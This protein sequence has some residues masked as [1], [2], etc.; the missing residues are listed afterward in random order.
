MVFFQAALLAGYGYAHL[1]TSRLETRRQ[2]IVHAVLLTLPLWVLPISIAANRV[3]PVD[4]NPIPWLL[5]LMVTVVGLP[6]LVVSTTAPLLQQWFTRTGHR[7]AKDPYFLY[8]ASN[9]GSLL[10]LLA[11]PTLV[12]PHL[13]LGDQ[14]RWWAIGYGLFV[15]CTIGC[16]W[17]VLRVAVR[18]TWRKRSS[19][20]VSTRRDSLK[21]LP[22][23]R[24][25]R[26]VMLAFV[27]SSLMLGIT[28][29][30]STD[31]AAIPLLWVIPLALYLLTFILVFARR[32]IVSQA[33]MVRLMPFVILPLVTVMVSDKTQP[34]WLLI[35]LHVLTFFVTAM[36]C[37]GALAQDRP[38]PNRL[39]EFYL[40]LSVGGVLGGLFN[41]LIAPVVFDTVMEYPLV[42]ILACLLR[43]G[44][45]TTATRSQAKWL[46]YAMPAALA[47]TIVALALNA[48]TVGPVADP[49]TL[50][51]IAV[52]ATLLC[53]SFRQRPVRF[54]LA[55]GAFLLIGR[56]FTTG[57]EYA[58]HIE[59]SFFGVY[60]VLRTHNETGVY[61]SL[62][63]GT[64][65][66]G[67][68]SRDP[69]RQKEPLTYYHPS[70]PLGDIMSAFKQGH[71]PPRIA[72][73]G[74][75]TGSISCFSRPAQQWTFYEIDPVIQ[76]IATNPH[77][78]S[79]VNTCLPN[80]R[81][82][83]G[84]A[85]LSLARAPD[86]TYGLIVVD[87][88]S[89]DAIPIHLM[90]RE[91]LL[92]YLAKLAKGGLLT[93]HI[94]NRYL[95]L[96]PVLGNLA[97]HAGVACVM[98]WDNDDTRMVQ[99]I[100]PS[101]WVVLARH[102]TNLGTLATNTH[103]QP[104]PAQPNAPLWSDDFSNLLSVFRWR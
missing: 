29:Y 73:I 26:W 83:L 88:F 20:S 72:A 85:R 8:A 18:T 12:E 86:H 90:T 91:A 66:H 55:V 81:V 49:I 42:L 45:P 3:P 58:L 84:D 79:Y 62:M 65:L 53:Y 64:T 93:F 103:W 97:A 99:G 22:I 40:W 98:R 25:L 69:T 21:P 33:C 101:K 30:L 15:V 75:G 44:S 63:H 9:G 32:P 38:A 92:L 36:V 76:R 67:M 61:H 28:T 27:P 57:W 37:H 104:L 96:A 41:A 78:F 60:R 47:F 48:R 31:I 54:G 82:V 94:S 16:A 87:A 71:A 68:Q 102:A 70:G 34:A 39:T 35:P 50:L 7:Q 5:G 80:P 19:T 43:P 51:L 59:R 1:A 11:Y 56:F 95:N 13:L 4:T 46:D 2:L 23:A 10:A 77:Y 52:P 24:R 17:L 6:F 89:S 14:S 74:L 100:T